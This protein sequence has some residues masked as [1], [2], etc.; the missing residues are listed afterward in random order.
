V[1]EAVQRRYGADGGVTYYGLEVSEPMYRAAS[2]RFAGVPGVTIEHTDVRRQSVQPY[3]PAVVLAVLTLQFI[4][5][6]Y[7]AHVLR[8][9]YQ[10]LP[11][12]G[13]LLLV[14]KVLGA[15]A[16]ID[17][18]MVR[19]YHVLKESQGYSG[20]E[21]ARKAAALEGVLVPLTAG[22]N[23]DALRH[24]GFREVDCF[25]RYLNFGAWVAVK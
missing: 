15:T 13:A 16:E 14:E 22:W 23:A 19:H 11:L 10:A 4:P 6:N 25:W 5:I 7:R 12:G 20:E 3:R 18:T 24:A 9:I 8:D 17:A 2:Q 1:R 21:V